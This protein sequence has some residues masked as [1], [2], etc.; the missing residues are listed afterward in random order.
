MIMHGPVPILMASTYIALS[1]LN[2]SLS[3]RELR[4]FNICI[5]IITFKK[6]AL[7]IARHIY[8]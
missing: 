2:T 1:P 3:V 4:D 8:L 5:L 6:M 7:N